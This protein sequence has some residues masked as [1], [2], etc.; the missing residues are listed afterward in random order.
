MR[1][2]FTGV[3]FTPGR[4]LDVV[5]RGKVQ[6]PPEPARRRPASSSSCRFAVGG[7]RLVLRWEG[8]GDLI[9]DVFRQGQDASVCSLRI[10][11]DADETHVTFYDPASDEGQEVYP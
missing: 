7:F 9:A 4:G 11:D 1:H 5:V 2:S 10:V 6:A 8:A 3:T